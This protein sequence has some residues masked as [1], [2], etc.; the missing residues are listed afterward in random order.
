MNEA[1]SM[2]PMKLRD[3]QATCVNSSSSLIK[4]LDTLSLSKK[5]YI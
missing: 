5:M 4:I 3:T 2:Y 1:P